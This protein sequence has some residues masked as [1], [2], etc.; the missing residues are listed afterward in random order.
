MTE[1][2]FRVPVDLAT[3][4]AAR[5]VC[6]ECCA[7]VGAPCLERARPFGQKWI[8]TYHDARIELAAQKRAAEQQA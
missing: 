3:D 2:I 6:P 4:E 7:A 1:G 8:S 5:V